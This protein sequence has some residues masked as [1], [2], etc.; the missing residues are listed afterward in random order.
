MCCSIPQPGLSHISPIAFWQSNSQGLCEARLSG[1]PRTLRLWVLH[2]RHSTASQMM[3]SNFISY[4]KTTAYEG[5]IWFL[6]C[7]S[8]LELTLRVIKLFKNLHQLPWVTSTNVLLR[9][10]DM[11]LTSTP[12]VSLFTWHILTWAHQPLSAK[13]EL[14]KNPKIISNGILFDFINYFFGHLQQIRIWI[15]KTH[16]VSVSTSTIFC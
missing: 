8:H 6:S 2:L 4:Q 12:S 7:F 11:K 13:S 1:A 3:D 5:L 15:S 10:N 14:K 9:P 16:E